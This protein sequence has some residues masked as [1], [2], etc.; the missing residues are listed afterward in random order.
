MTPGEKRV[1]LHF[2]DDYSDALGNRSCNDLELA[3]LMPD[4]AERVALIKYA[5]EQ[6]GD[7]QEFDPKHAA[8]PIQ[9]DFFVLFALV[10]KLK[11]EWGMS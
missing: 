2:L 4:R 3:E 10:R 5:H 9:T 1:L 11:A 6:N 7:P 8:G